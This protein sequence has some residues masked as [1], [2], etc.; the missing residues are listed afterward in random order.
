MNNAEKIRALDT[1]KL[2]EFLYNFSPCIYCV[3][4]EYMCPRQGQD[5][6]GGIRAWLERED[7]SGE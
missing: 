7:E 6:L 4:Q 5:C 3:H 1:Y 2:A